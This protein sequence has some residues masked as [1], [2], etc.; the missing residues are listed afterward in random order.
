L[1][2]HF[3]QQA[4]GNIKDEA[5]DSIGVRN[6]WRSLYPRD[7]LSDVACD[8]TK[9][10]RRPLR[11]QTSLLADTFFELIVSKG[12]HAAVGVVNKN[13]LFGAEQSLANS[14]RPDLIG[15]HNASGI[16]NNV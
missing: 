1:L 12:Q 2:L 7:A 10:L 14:Q 8:V 16:A 6:K 3:L 13:Y 15:C 11:L 4:S 9:R 5:P